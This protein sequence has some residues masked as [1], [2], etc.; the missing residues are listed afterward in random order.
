MS[1]VGWIATFVELAGVPSKDK[2][3]ESI[4]KGMDTARKAP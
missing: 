3:R 2:E 1:R 4:A